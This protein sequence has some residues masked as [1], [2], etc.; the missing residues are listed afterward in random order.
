MNENLTFGL[1]ITVL[2]LGIAG[3]I[4]VGVFINLGWVLLIIGGFGL[5]II[6]LQ[7]ASRRGDEVVA[8]LL[9]GSSPFLIYYGLRFLGIAPDLLALFFK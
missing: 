2:V 7:L 4:C 6:C 1:F 3:L 8:Y 9:V 5:L